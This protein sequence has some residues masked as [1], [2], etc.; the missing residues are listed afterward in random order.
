M[1][2]SFAREPPSRHGDAWTSESHENR[3][4]CWSMVPAPSEVIEFAPP[5]GSLP[6][7]PSF[8]L[9]SLDKA[10]L[11]AMQ[12]PWSSF[13]PTW[14]LT[15]LEL[16]GRTG[17]TVIAISRGDDVVLVPDGHEALRLGDVLALAGTSDAIEAARALLER[18]AHD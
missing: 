18:G 4:I 3:N 11:A 12:P 15:E 17:A 5:H 7:V 8:P 6:R 9:D 16:R 14:K 2:T 13:A 1:P 10:C